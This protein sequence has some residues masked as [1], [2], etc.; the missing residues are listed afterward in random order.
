MRHA[1][2][3]I[4][5]VFFLALGTPVK[6][7]RYW[8]GMQ[9]YAEGDYSTAFEI[10][11]SLAERGNKIAQYALAMLYEH[12]E[13]VSQNDIKAVHWYRMAAEQGFVVAQ[14]KLGVKYATGKG[15]LED[16]ETSHMWFNIARAKGHTEAHKSLTI[17]NDLL[18]QDQILQAQARARKCLNSNYQDCD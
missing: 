11:L 13:G 7:D 2:L 8:D 14:Y 1:L 4:L 5:T 17:L 18:K 6:A 10:W 16:Y 15:V 3:A 9:A 12:G